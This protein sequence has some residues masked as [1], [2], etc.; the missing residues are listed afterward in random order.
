MHRSRSQR[1]IQRVTPQGRKVI[2]YERKANSLPHCAICK[3]ELNGIKITRSGGKSR[4]TN[5]RRFGGVLCS[6]CTS[7][8]IKAASRIEHGDMKLGDISIR[9]RVFV[10]Q[11]ISH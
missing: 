6:G 1:R 4:R 2:H 7:G 10:L 5:A 3:A 8:V 11:M 9:Q